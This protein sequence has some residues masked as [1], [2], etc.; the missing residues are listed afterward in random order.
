MSLQQ[1]C[2]REVEPGDRERGVRYFHQRRVSLGAREADGIAAT[3][4]GSEGAVYE[5]QIDWSR[6]EYESLLTVSCTCPRFS[7]FVVCKHVWATMV[8][9]DRAQFNELVPGHGPLELALAPPGDDEMDAE[10]GLHALAS[11]A[12]ASFEEARPR[13]AWPQ[14]PS[15]YLLDDLSIMAGDRQA[16]RLRRHRPQSPWQRQ[17][18]SIRNALNHTAEPSS[19]WPQHREVQ[20]CL[21]LDES[22]HRGYLVIELYQRKAKRDG[23]LGRTIRVALGREPLDSF[24]DPEDQEILRVLES[25]AASDREPGQ[26]RYVPPLDRT[27]GSVPAVLYD[28]VLPRLCATGRFGWVRHESKDPSQA[29]TLAWDDGDPWSFSLS[30][31]SHDEQDFMSLVGTLRRGDERRPLTEPLLLLAD[32]IVV[33]S[34]RIARL[35][36][37]GTFP[38]IS[39]LRR[40]DDI[41]IPDDDR[42]TFFDLLDDMP[43]L[44]ELELPSDWQW[45]TVSPQPE[46]RLILFPASKTQLSGA[47]AFDYDGFR[48]SAK[49][50]SELALDRQGQRRIQR[51]VDSERRAWARLHDLGVQPASGRAADIYDV[52]VSLKVFREI[53]DTLLDEGWVVEADGGRIRQ[54]GNASFSVSSNIDWF[55]LRGE[56]EFD[57]KM[58]PLP[59]L[60]AA[61]RDEDRM[62]RLDDGSQGILP[63]EWLD[64][65]AP[66]AKLAQGEEGESIR[67]LPSQAA[68]LDALL[69]A[70]PQVDVDEGFAHLRERLAAFDRVTPVSETAGFVGQLRGYQREGLGWLTFLESFRFGGC[71]A[72]DMGLGKTVQVLAAL[73]ARSQSLTADQ[74][75]PSLI[76][77]PRSVVTNWQDEAARFTP[78]LRVAIYSG[79]QRKRQLEALANHDLVVTTY[80]LLRRDILQLK[81]ITFDYVVLDEAQAIKNPA[82]Q[83]SKASRLLQANHR[84][85]LTGTPVENHL[86]E[87]WSIFEFLNPGMLGRLPAFKGL[88][89]QRVLGDATLE[90]VARALRPFI[91]RRTKAAVL[92]DL[93]EKTEQTL[94]CELGSSQRRLYKELR[95]HYRAALDRRI[96]EQGLMRS[97][98]QVLEALLRLRQA[99][100]HPALIDPTRSDQPSAKLEVLLEQLSEVL[101]SGHKAL[102]FSQFTS[103]LAL[104][105]RQMKDQGITY[106]YLDG[107]T[108]NRKQRV[109]R[110]QTDPA[111]Q[112]FLISLKAGGLGLNLTAADYVFILDP[113]WNPAVEAQAVDRAHRIG[114]T[115]PVFA[116]RLIASDTVEEKIL[117]LQQSKRQLADAILNASGSMI[118]DLTADDLQLLL[119]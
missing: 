38:W 83:A 41:R 34:D 48:V 90:T 28:T 3:V 110:F 85:A 102:V 61:V 92:E 62:L 4:E 91:L 78:E 58:V 12:E 88:A 117:E 50:N 64:R 55:E 104:V 97:K 107:K 5:V 75:Q 40:E 74:R 51:R 72:D 53:I 71:L 65:F 108:R 16:R 79:P 6:A 17:L 18:I 63:Q 36:D 81:N 57:G 10:A 96:E 44:P 59:Q 80:G 24:P 26:G 30:L 118:R 84:L 94:F 29:S 113:W 103:L 106:E 99:A 37:E 8:A 13:P 56:L 23:E 112:V 77:V 67:Y 68:L 22:L 19:P 69:A 82:A 73:L 60:L 35:A 119:S 7:S 15:E 47:V 95:D 115:R 1:R 98:I 42:E 86:G 14:M 114:Q 101:A 89:G 49:R 9:H 20:Y 43:V 109:E 27:Q 33:W 100:C 2:L 105:E 93:P 87:L 32:G 21:N 52:K 11:H 116:Y 111:C 46:P 31:E 76:V 39:L 54:A 70:E 45:Q 25:H 66:L